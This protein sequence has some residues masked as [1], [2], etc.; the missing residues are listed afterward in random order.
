MAHTIAMEIV[1]KKDTKPKIDRSTFL[2]LSPSGPD[3]VGGEKHQDFAQCGSCMMFTGDYLK[4][5]EKDGLCT[6]LG[7][8]FPIQAIGSCGLYAPGPN[9]VDAKTM[10]SVPSNQAGYVERP[11]R[12]ENCVDFDEKLSICHLFHRLNENEPETYELDVHVEAKGCCNGQR[13]K[14]P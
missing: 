6:I 7:P 10:K 9:H 12:C 14:F 1:L 3:P 4:K 5:G 8:D 2:Y 11:V 13:A